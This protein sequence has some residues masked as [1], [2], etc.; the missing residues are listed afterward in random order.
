MGVLSYPSKGNTAGVV[1]RLG[2][3]HPRDDVSIFGRD[4]VRTIS[5]IHLPSNE[6]GTGGSVPWP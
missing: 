2:A 6:V 5:G 4:N 3:G 1:T